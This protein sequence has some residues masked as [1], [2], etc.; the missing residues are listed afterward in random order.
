MSA[1]MKAE[2]GS[3]DAAREVYQRLYESSDDER[4]RQMVVAQ[5]M[6]MQWLEDRNEIQHVLDRF[7]SSSAEGR[8][9]SSWQPIANQFREPRWHIDRETGAP[10]DPSG[11]SYRLIN[12]GCKVDLDPNSK[13]PR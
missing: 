6:R 1:R 12:G 11:V 13:V 10:L 5:L 8:C 2:G 4:V 9:V 7:Q 3:P